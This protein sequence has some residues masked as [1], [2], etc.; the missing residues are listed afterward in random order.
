MRESVLRW[1]GGALSERRAFIYITFIQI[2]HIC[3]AE[4][5]QLGSATVGVFCVGRLTTTHARRPHLTVSRT[6]ARAHMRSGV[7]PSPRRGPISERHACTATTH[8][9]A[10]ETGQP[11]SARVDVFCVGRLIATHASH[12]ELATKQ[13]NRTDAN[14]NHEFRLASTCLAFATHTHVYHRSARTYGHS[15]LQRPPTGFCNTHALGHFANA[16]EPISEHR[17]CAAMTH[18]CVADA[19]QPGSATVE[20]FGRLIYRT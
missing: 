6:N 14:K 4:T 18:M 17:A 1:P 2:T 12:P 11:G 19:R 3:V 13:V 16:H 9:C 15:E 5:R 20:V 8:M 10:A 7:L